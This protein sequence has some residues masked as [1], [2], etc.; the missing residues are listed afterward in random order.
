[1]DV[2]IIFV[3][4]KT[5]DLLYNAINSIKKYTQNCSYEIIVVDNSED[6]KIFNDLELNKTRLNYKLIK[7]P[8]NI[9]VGNGGNLGSKFACGDYFLFLNTDVI[10]LNNAVFELFNFL[11]EN[12]DVGIVGGNLYNK[13]MTPNLTF[14]DDGI[15]KYL[16]KKRF[17]Y[18]GYFFSKLKRKSKTFNFSNMPHQVN[19]TIIG[20]VLMIS[21]N[22]FNK[23]GGYDKD[24]FMYGEE[25]LLCFRMRNELHKKIYNLP[26]AKIIHLDGGSYRNSNLI[27]EKARVNGDCIYYTKTIGKDNTINF[28]K[29]LSKI[30]FIKQILYCIALNSEKAKLYKIKRKV[31]FDKSNELRINS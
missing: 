28:Y 16:L 6:T 8:G 12:T 18:I 21:R 4:Y 26:S 10:F 29:N 3:N 27:R 14:I 31:A 7:S 1:M 19:N 22:D 5:N 13:D 15:N 24:I 30:Y 17:N 2:S 11:R 23:L 9:G 20:A 25:S